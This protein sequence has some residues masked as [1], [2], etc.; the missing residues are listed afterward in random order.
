MSSDNKSYIVEIPYETH[1]GDS[2]TAMSCRMT[3]EDA[4][5]L[6]HKYKATGWNP[7]IREYDALDDLK[8]SL[9]VK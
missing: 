6:Y 2:A 7:T 1:D 4:E 5:A 3:Y 8:V 9:V